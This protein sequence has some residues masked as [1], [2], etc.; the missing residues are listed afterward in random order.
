MIP[1][2]KN[3]KEMEVY[4][5]PPLPPPHIHTHSPNSTAE[6]LHKGFGLQSGLFSPCFSKVP[7]GWEDVKLN[8][9]DVVWPFMLIPFPN[10]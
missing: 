2:G 9:R 10:P 3:D 8:F 7:D 1:S 5:A 4:E 6:I